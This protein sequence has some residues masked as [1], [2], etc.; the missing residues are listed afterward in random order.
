MLSGNRES[1]YA[2]LIPVIRGKTFS[3]YDVVYGLCYGG[4]SSFSA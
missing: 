3:D 2:C 4:V 1:G